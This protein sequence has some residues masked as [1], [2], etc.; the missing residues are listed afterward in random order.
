MP[1]LSSQSSDGLKN[2][3]PDNDDVAN[4][5]KRIREAYAKELEAALAYRTKFFWWGVI[6]TSVCVVA[7]IGILIFLV[8]RGV[9]ETAVGVAFISG[10][11]VE[12]VGVAVV[13]AKYLFPE[14]GGSAIRAS[15]SAIAEEDNA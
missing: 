2:A 4:I 5:E 13:I 7:S 15:G 10:L 11:A 8:C 9:Y 6:V 1:D 14:N 12:V 3:N